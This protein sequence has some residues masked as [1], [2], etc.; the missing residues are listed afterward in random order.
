MKSAAIAVA[1]LAASAFALPAA[2]QMSMASGYVGATFGQAEYKDACGSV[3]AGGSC[4]EKDTAWR[5]L[6]GM[7]INRNFAAEIGY[8]NLGEITATAGASRAN[9]QVDVFELVGIGAFPI[10]NMFSIYGKLGGYYGR[11]EL[12]SNVAGI[13]GDETNTGLTYG[14]GVQFDVMRQLGVRLEWQRYD[15]VGG[16]RTGEGDINVISVGAIW[17]FR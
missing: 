15:N 16:D 12:T 10:A 4:D 1:A 8:H 11:A 13:G 9:L 17:R 5:V 14:A 6:A 2:A 3:I 7:Q